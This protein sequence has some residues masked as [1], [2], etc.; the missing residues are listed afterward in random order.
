MAA[1]RDDNSFQSLG[2]ADNKP[3]SCNVC[4]TVLNSQELLQNHLNT[5]RH[6]CQMCNT[7]F[8]REDQLN[9]HL[10]THSSW[11][12]GTEFRELVCPEGNYTCVLCNNAFTSKDTLS[13]HMLSHGENKPFLCDVCCLVFTDA[14][15]LNAHVQTENHVQGNPHKCKK[16]NENFTTEELLLSHQDTHQERKG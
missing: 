9:T 11:E 3:Y 12:N 16:C 7:T 1:L 8:E 4:Y 2:H 15:S 10:L 13:N 14:K 6:V 5:H